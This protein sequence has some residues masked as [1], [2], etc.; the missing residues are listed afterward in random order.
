MPLFLFIRVHSW[1]LN[2]PLFLPGEMPRPQTLARYVAAIDDPSRPELSVRWTDAGALTITGPVPP[3]DIVDLQVTAGPG[4]QA[5]QNGHQIPVEED[6]LG[7]L[8]LHPAPA[9]ATQIDLR[10][11]GIP[12][13]DAMAAIGFSLST[14]ISFTSV[15]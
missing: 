1:P 3:A 13:Q 15:L 10:Y 8:V 7:F 9:L 14:S 5:T 11:R 4:W 6:R 12:E 2:T